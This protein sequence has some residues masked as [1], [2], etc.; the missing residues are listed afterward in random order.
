MV[1]ILKRKAEQAAAVAVC[2]IMAVLTITVFS[3][4]G[5]F[6]SGST[7]DTGFVKSNVFYVKD[8]LFN[9]IP[10]PSVVFG[11]S[12]E[13]LTTPLDAGDIVIFINTDAMGAATGAR[14]IG[15]IVD[16]T[17]GE[18]VRCTVR[19]GFD[20]VQ[21]IPEANIVAKAT[22]HSRALG[23]IVAFA[24]SSTGVIMIAVLPCAAIIFMELSKPFRRNRSDNIEVTPVK[25][26]DEVPTFIPN[27]EIGELNPNS[28][29][30]KPEKN[31]KISAKAAL[32]AYK[33]TLSMDEEPLPADTA[34]SS[35]DTIKESLKLKTAKSEET[36]KES[37][38]SKTAQ[39]PKE[40]KITPPLFVPA[41]K[42][43]PPPKPKIL[44]FS[45]NE[46]IPL[47]EPPKPK[48]KS[49]SSLKQIPVTEMTS[50]GAEK[51]A[52]ASKLKPLSSEKLAAAIA[53]MNARAEQADG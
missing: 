10:A 14:Q 34:P 37:K 3:V 16:V 9:L 28:K 19:I 44:P 45:L 18:I 26:Q 40:N 29:D 25:K 51:P 27:V 43:E 47:P 17:V 21:I 20:E 33:Q 39:D 36:Q 11:E 52:A 41:F 7:G 13:K 50:K 35:T 1:A 15:E 32:K 48:P 53:A 5:L 22:S 4:A 31:K 23:G 38:D 12:V 46:P 30:G 2:I 42:P 24:S 49:E 8:N 6:S